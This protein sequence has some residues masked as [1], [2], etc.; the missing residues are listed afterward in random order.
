MDVFVSELL[1]E[2][3]EMAFNSYGTYPGAVNSEL[4]QERIV[5]YL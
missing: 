1:A 2:Q 5:I 4:F 3:E